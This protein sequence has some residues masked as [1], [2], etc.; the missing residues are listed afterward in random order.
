[1][2]NFMDSFDVLTSRFTIH[3]I[4]MLDN[5]R[6]VIKLQEQHQQSLE[7][8]IKTLTD[9]LQQHKKSL[10]D[11]KRERDRNATHSQVN[12]NKIS[13]T[14]SELSIKTK[15][16]ADLTWELDEM[17]T[18][19]SHVQQQLDTVIAERI[20]LEKSLE[21]I[22]DDRNE[23]RDKLRVGISTVRKLLKQNFSS[24]EINRDYQLN[25]C[26]SDGNCRTK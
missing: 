19:L 21:T 26:F 3:F 20:A 6:D 17:R 8:E 12:A 10:N 2:A 24:I 5:Q 15:L 9:S 23:V 13:A 1:M 16:I 11:M 22:T 18:K 25:F 14:Q 4:G 7:N